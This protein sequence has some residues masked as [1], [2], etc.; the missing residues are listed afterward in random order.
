MTAGNDDLVVARLALASIV[1]GIIAD[2]LN[3]LT[4]DVPEA[5]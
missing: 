1:K 3:T 5:M 4:I 2:G